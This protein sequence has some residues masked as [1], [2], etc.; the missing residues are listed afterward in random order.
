M[1]LKTLHIFAVF[2][3]AKTIIKSLEVFTSFEIF[4]IFF[5]IFGY[6]NQIFW[7]F[8]PISSFAYEGFHQKLHQ[9]DTT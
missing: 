2:F 1:N 8:S 6:W 7:F 9:V 4:K 5:Q 3:S